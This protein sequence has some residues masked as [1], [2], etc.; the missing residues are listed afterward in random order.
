MLYSQPRKNRLSLLHTT[1]TSNIFYHKS[2]LNTFKNQFH[3]IKF[4]STVAKCYSFQ[5]PQS[6][7]L[8]EISLLFWTKITRS[9]KMFSPNKQ[10]FNLS[11]QTVESFLLNFRILKPLFFQSKLCVRIGNYNE[12]TIPVSL[13]TP[14]EN[15]KLKITKRFLPR[16]HRVEYVN[17]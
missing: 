1:S 13:T 4:K 7:L 3:D 5:N 10:Y 16:W 11:V 17:S 14:T 15:F 9:L 8:Q 12:H 6:R 2:S